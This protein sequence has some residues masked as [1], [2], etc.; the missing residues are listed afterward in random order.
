MGRSDSDGCGACP[1]GE[2]GLLWKL[3][4]NR[5]S[6]RSSSFDHRLYTLLTTPPGSISELGMAHSFFDKPLAG[7]CRTD[8]SC[9][10]HRNSSLLENEGTASGSKTA[11]L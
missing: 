10:N 5:C 3:A 7:R 2:A 11:D 4:P 9:T 8:H 6:S 1:S